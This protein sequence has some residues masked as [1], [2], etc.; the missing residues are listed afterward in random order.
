MPVHN[1][2]LW[3]QFLCPHTLNVPYRMESGAPDNLVYL[4]ETYGEG[5]GD[6]GKKALYK[7]LYTILWVSAVCTLQ[8]IIY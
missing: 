1:T 3:K 6:E 2:I 8:Y 4:L 5:R 7:R